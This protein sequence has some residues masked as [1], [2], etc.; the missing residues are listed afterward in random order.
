MLFIGVFCLVPAIGIFVLSATDI[1]GVPRVP[2]HWVGLANFRTFFSAAQLGENEIA[3][4]HTLIFGA[5]TTVIQNVIGLLIAVALN[6]KIRGR[7]FFRAVVFLPTVLGVTML[8]L[9]WS[10]FFNPGQGP[11]ASALSWFGV[12]SAFFGDPHLALSL[13]I[14]V[15]I[16][17]STGFAMVIYLS[18]LQAIPN[19]FYEAASIDGAS[20]W[21]KLRSITVPMLAPSVTANVLIAIVWA[22]QSYQLDYVLTG[23]TN[24]AT[25]LLPLRI[26][27]NAFYGGGGISGGI[28]SQGYASAISVIQFILVA[29]IT[30]GAFAYLRRREMQL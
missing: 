30:L 6:A 18:G 28:E 11:A 16:W 7:A 10:L 8:G 13:V 21:R 25:S 23:T 3:V 17:A 4:E 15:Q 9:I 1:T 27:V 5:A 12:N 29:I 22:L 20:A 26:F 14:F 2:I 19:D 24:P